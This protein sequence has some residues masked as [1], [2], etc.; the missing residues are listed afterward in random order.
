MAQNNGVVSNYYSGQGIVLLATRDVNG[1]PEGFINIGNVSDLTISIDVSETDHK[2]STSG[3]RAVDLTLTTE[4]K[5]AVAMTMES[6][7]QENLTLALAGTGSSIAS[8]TILD[9]VI[10]AKVG[11][12]IP[13]AHMGLSA[14]VI[15]DVTDTTTYVLD[16]NYTINSEVGSI[17]ILSTAAQTAAGAA[18]LIAEDD[19]LHVDY[20]YAAYENV[21]GLT[22]ANPVRWLRF[23]GLN[24][25][26]TN[27]PVVVE[28]FK[29]SVT[30]LA[31]RALINEDIAQMV[32][33]GDALYDQLRTTG[34]NFFRERF[35]K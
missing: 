4:Q 26:R 32:I 10:V 17:N 1:G 11:K 20:S 3:L 2:E 25:A 9:E 19:V 8:G 16:D 6:F 5:V 24:T 34:S 12:T 27:S 30:P 28:V 23:E 14:I 18:N 29:M 13:T 31:E 35:L 22:S 15:Q 7:N 21:E 33:E